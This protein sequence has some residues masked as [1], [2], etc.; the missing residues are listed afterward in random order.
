MD[1]INIPVR[2]K[3]NSHLNNLRVLEDITVIIPT[4]G[5]PILSNCL[6]SI[7]GGTSLPGCLIVIDQGSNPDVKIWIGDIVSKGV[8]AIHVQSHERSPSSARNAGIAQVKTKF[9]AAIDD[10]CIAA[11][12]WLDAMAACLEKRPN[13]IIT[14]R[15]EPAGDG[16]PPS[17]VTFPEPRQYLRPSIR[18]MNPITTG[19]Y[20]CSLETMRKIGPFDINLFTAEDADWGYRALKLGVAIYYEPGVIVHHF[21]WRNIS[22][23][24]RTYDEYAWGQGAFFGKHLKQG[25]WSMVLRSLITFYRGLKSLLFGWIKN[26]ETRI[27]IGIARMTHFFPGLLN[28]LWGFRPKGRH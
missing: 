7:A 22:D 26:D 14:G 28:G 17:V 1:N 5:R 9:F 25:D 19:N 18:L 12:N 20:G 27:L 13:D 16:N 24:R 11:S 21:H 4:V 15:V 10:D 3:N 2:T 8:N 6:N 23:L